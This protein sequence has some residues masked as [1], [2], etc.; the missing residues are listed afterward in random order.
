MSPALPRHPYGLKHGD[1]ALPAEDGPDG[2]SEV[3]HRMASVSALT[4]D[5]RSLA[6]PL[7]D[8]PVSAPFLC[9]SGPCPSNP[10]PDDNPQPI[11][12]F[13]ASPLPVCVDGPVSSGKPVALL[14]PE[15]F[16][17]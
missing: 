9:P 7:T 5:H 8:L 14:T 15:A 12:S 3:M 16:P 4:P 2:F 17:G 1:E 11:S 6:P 13:P 10:W